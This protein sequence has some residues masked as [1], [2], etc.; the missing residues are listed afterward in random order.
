MYPP[1]GFAYPPKGKYLVLQVQLREQPMYMFSHVASKLEG[2]S[3]AEAHRAHGGPDKGDPERPWNVV[4]PLCQ[5]VRSEAYTYSA[6]DARLW[7]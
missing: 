2:M 5:K 1:P 6:R 4:L 7:S 3:I